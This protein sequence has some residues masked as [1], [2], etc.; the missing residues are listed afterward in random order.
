VDYTLPRIED[1]QDCGWCVSD[2]RTASALAFDLVWLR[3]A[4]PGESKPFYCPA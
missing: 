4:E 2:Q 1:S 3:R